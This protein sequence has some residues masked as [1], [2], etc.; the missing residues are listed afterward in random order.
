MQTIHDNA[1]LAAVL[2]AAPDGTSRTLI[3]RI[4]HDAKASE[5]W[6]L[7]CIVLVEHNDTA[8]DFEEVLGFDPALGPLEDGEPYWCWEERHGETIEILI[9]AGNEGFVWFVIAPLAWY[10]AH[11]HCQTGT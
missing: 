4:A 6:E 10:A 5:L 8:Q 7:T 2:A 9:T 3:E 11:I 1:T